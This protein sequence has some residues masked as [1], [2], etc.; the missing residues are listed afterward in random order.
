MKQYIKSI[1]AIYFAGLIILISQSGCKEHTVISS[2]FAPG[3]N[4]VAIFTDSFTV[5]AKTK[6]YDTVITNNA[7]QNVYMGAGVVQDPV[8][9]KKNAGFYFQVIPGQLGLK[10]D[11]TITIDSAFLILPYSGFTYGDMSD[12]NAIESFSVYG[13]AD[14]TFSIDTFFYYANN[15]LALSKLYNTGNTNI[16]HLQDSISIYG[17]N[18][19]PHLRMNIGANGQLVKDLVAAASGVTDNPT[20]VKNFPGLYVRATDTNNRSTALPYFQLDGSDNYDYANVL[21]YCHTT[22]AVVGGP[23]TDTLTRTFYFSSQYCAHF[24]NITHVYSPTALSYFQSTAVSDAD[25]LV[26]NGP[27]AVLDVKIG[28]IRSLLKADP[29]THITKAPIIT[30]AQLVLTVSQ[31]STAYQPPATIFP[32]SVLYQ[33]STG[34]NFLSTIADA[35]PLTSASAFAFIDGNAKTNS[36]MTQYTINVPRELQLALTKAVTDT[37]T[38]SLDTLHLQLSGYGT[39]YGAYRAIIGGGNN[40]N[41]SVKMKFNVVYSK[42]K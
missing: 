33:T 9:G 31:P 14:H 18:V 28:G 29:N 11:A 1:L 5:L 40:S 23:I 27:G 34:A 8:L 30:Q 20:F 35:Y 39:L 42:L 25:V 19:R 3:I 2:G 24:N 4:N 12:H 7:L 17:V 21:L 6:Y 26:E 41:A 16:Y 37:M 10:Y 38:K 15:T 36:G 22:P 13:V 32:N